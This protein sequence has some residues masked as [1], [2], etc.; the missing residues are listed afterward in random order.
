MWNLLKY[1]GAWNKSHKQIQLGANIKRYSVS[2]S[3]CTRN[4]SWKTLHLGYFRKDCLNWLHSAQAGS[5]LRIL[6]FSL[7]DAECSLWIHLTLTI[8]FLVPFL[9]SHRWF[10]C[11]VWF[12][13]FLEAGTSIPVFWSHTKKIYVLGEGGRVS[14]R[15]QAICANKTLHEQIQAA[16]NQKE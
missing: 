3:W 1:V 8:S 4:I 14:D 9:W 15:C 6:L 2:V 7:Y 5:E 12:Q 11:L 16:A 10:N 13:L